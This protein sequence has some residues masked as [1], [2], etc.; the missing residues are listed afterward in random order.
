[1]TKFYDPSEDIGLGYEWEKVDKILNENLSL[2]SKRVIFGDQIGFPDN[3]FN[4]GQI[5]S[6]IQSFTCIKKNLA[7]IQQYL[8]QKPE[9]ATELEN[10]ILMLKC[11][12]DFQKGI[13]VTF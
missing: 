13:Y 2:N 5:G 8:E 10:L 6:Y 3:Y 7:I 9:M 11:A 4:P 12:Q 1:M